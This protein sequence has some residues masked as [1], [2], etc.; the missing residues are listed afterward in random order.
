MTLKDGL[1]WIAEPVID[2]IY[3][4]APALIGIA[5]LLPQDLLPKS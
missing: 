3:Q 4:G 2:F 5:I 1:V